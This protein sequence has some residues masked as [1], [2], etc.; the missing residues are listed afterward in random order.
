[1][2]LQGLTSNYVQSFCGDTNKSSILSAAVSEGHLSL[3]SRIFCSFKKTTE[4]GNKGLWYIILLSDKHRVKGLNPEEIG[5]STVA[6]LGRDW[7]CWTTMSVFNS[8]MS[9]VCKKA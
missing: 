7:C 3:S 2:N 4:L 8:L 9:L 5:F 6:K 1:M